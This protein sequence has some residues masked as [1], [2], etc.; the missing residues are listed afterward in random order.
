MGVI[1]PNLAYHYWSL[2]IK[3]AGKT[4][5]EQP[6]IMIPGTEFEPEKEIEH[7]EDKGHTGGSS[8]TMGMYRKK[9]QPVAQVT[10]IKHDTSK[11]GKITGI[12][13]LDM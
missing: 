1:A 12:Y 7:E 13:S 10:K 11:D 4:A 5:P 8:L 3:P 6:L 9:K 2:G